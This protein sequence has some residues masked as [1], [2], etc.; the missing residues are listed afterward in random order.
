MK[1]HYR[2]SINFRDNF[3]FSF[4]SL[5]H[6]VTF[7]SLLKLTFLSFDVYFRKMEKEIKLEGLEVCVGRIRNIQQIPRAYR[8]GVSFLF[9]HFTK[10]SLTNISSFLSSESKNL[11][12]KKCWKTSLSSLD[13]ESLKLKTHKTTNDL[14]SNKL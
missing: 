7:A 12:Y 1:I 14:I 3:P 10:R 8:L 13:Q 9:E 11:R 2:F 4:Q 5:H 6:L